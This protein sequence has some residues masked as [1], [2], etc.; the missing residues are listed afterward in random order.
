MNTDQD[1]ERIFNQYKDHIGSALTVIMVGER[2]NWK[3]LVRKLTSQF[4]WS[5]ADVH[6]IRD[7]NNEM[8]VKNP[9]T[10]IIEERNVNIS[11]EQLK[12]ICIALGSSLESVLK[13]A[14]LLE[15]SSSRP[16]REILLDLKKEIEYQLWAQDEKEQ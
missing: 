2:I 3:K 5:S 14:A 12:H 15:E 7:L 13:C 1:L 6:A 8:A 4:N 11:F 9:V 16:E 10:G